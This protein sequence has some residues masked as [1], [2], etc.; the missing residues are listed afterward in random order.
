[1]RLRTLALAGVLALGATYAQQTVAPQIAR[2]ANDTP[3][4]W[5]KKFER[6]LDN[7]VKEYGKLSKWCNKNH[8]EWTGNYVR[9]RG[10]MFRPDHEELR[11]YFGYEKWEDGRWRQNDIKR[12]EFR[13]IID[14]DDPN[15]GK[16]PKNVAKAQTKIAGWFRGLGSKADKL[17][18]ETGDAAWTP[19]ADRAWERALMADPDGK[20]AKQAHQALEHPQFDGEYV[21]PFKLRF[22][23]ARK[24]R[25][26]AGE[27]LAAK[28]FDIEQVPADGFIPEA[29]LEAVGT[30]ATRM[31]INTTHSQEV[32]DRLAQWSMR[33]IEDI[34]ERYGFPEA[35]GDRLGVRKFD[36][37]KQGKEEL[38]PYL[39]NGAKW[40][41]AKIT[42]YLEYFSGMGVRGG[43]FVSASGDGA[44]SDDM[45]IHQSG[46]ATAGAAM[47]MALSDLGNRLGSNTSGIE[48]WLRESIAYD[49]TRRLTATTL[50][51]CGEFGKYGQDVTPKPGE[52]LWIQLARRQV[53]MDDDVALT[54]LW[55]LTLND[56]RG[57]ET[58]KGYALLQYLFEQDTAMAQ[59]FIWHALAHGTP[60]AVVD[61]Y[62]EWLGTEKPD[63][64]DA[65][66]ETYKNGAFN[67]PAYQAAMNALDD[68][69]REWIL[70]AW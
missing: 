48:D 51:T 3:A 61:V 42:K 44:G 29:G 5:E 9:R 50:T 46:H 25:R 45:V 62:S 38:K 2:A 19:L 34:T 70:K 11:A 55:H 22:L 68:R 35:V 20:Y 30:K 32:S 56:V 41:R 13:S 40:D 18:A 65:T 47:S 6:T 53:E 28:M 15:A 4:D 59:K 52:D 26:E 64:S 63:D 66:A 37:L 24:S 1:M 17:A 10:F 33:A 39:T 54:R 16:Y 60:A 7:A 12:D 43:T 23:E 67:Q 49:C 69:Y 27:A 36:V 8:L 58:V 31:L 21:S 57:P 14:E